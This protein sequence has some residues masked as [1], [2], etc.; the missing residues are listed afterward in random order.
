MAEIMAMGK[1]IITNMGWGDVDKI[2]NDDNG[3]LVI[4]NDKKSIKQSLTKLVVKKNTYLPHP[5]DDKNGVL[6]LKKGIDKYSNLY[7]ILLN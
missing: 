5:N 1:P 3:I 4:L 6:S 2:V 7:K